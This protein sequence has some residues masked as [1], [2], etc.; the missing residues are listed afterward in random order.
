MGDVEKRLRALGIELP[1]PSRPGANY[2][3]HVR[4]R[5]PALPDGTARAVERGAAV[6]RQARARVRRR[7]GPEAARLCALNLVAHVRAALDGDLD[8]VVRCVRVAGFVNSTPD[9]TGTVP[10][11]RRRLGRVRPDLRRSRPS[12]ADGRRRQRAALRRGGR[13]RGGVRDPLRGVSSRRSEATMTIKRQD[14]LDG[15]EVVGQDRRGDARRD[16]RGGAARRLDLGP[17]RRR[18]AR[19]RRARRPLGAADRV[20]VSGRRPAS[21]S[22][23]RSCMESRAD[24]GSSRATS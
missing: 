17:R 1:E 22:T 24:G 19:F 14:E 21:A 15:L 18:G 20:R 16:A 7:G 3:P 13:G 2:V 12:R 23:T 8:R 11:R 4:A 6:H 5:Q 9:F 10:G